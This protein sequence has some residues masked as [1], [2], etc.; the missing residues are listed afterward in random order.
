MFLS[1]VATCTFFTLL[2]VP[3]LRPCAA[4]PIPVLHPQG[5]VRGFLLIRSEGGSPI[6]YGEL[7]QTIHGDRV[8]SHLVYRFRDGSLDEETTVFTQHRVFQLVS[9]HH[10][11][12]G[13]FFSKPQDTLVLANGDVTTRTSEKDGSVKTENTHLD[14]PPDVSNG[15]IGTLIL[16]IDH[17][18]PGLKLGMVAPV[19]KG[20]LIQLAVT[21]DGE[22]SLSCV[23]GHSC[24]AAIFQI[25]PELGGLVGVIAPLVG[26]Q[27]DNIYLWVVQGDAPAF[28]RE[29]GQ[30]GEGGPVVSIELAGTS[31]SHSGRHSTSK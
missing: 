27:P 16:N 20:R 5:T 12:R 7:N 24:K 13:P 14:L 26:K 29:V 23:A 1:R 11:Q 9:D 15:M 25:K 10:I 28:V 18:G 19:G 3:A 2:L 6:G 8:T 30:L 17:K 4:E 21:P 22:G 31:F